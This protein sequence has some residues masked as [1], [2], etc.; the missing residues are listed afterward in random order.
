MII[1]F[2]KSNVEINVW[3]NLINLYFLLLGKVRVFIR[4]PL[5][6][7]I[8]KIDSLK[9]ETINFYYIW[10]LFLRGLLSYLNLDFLRI[11]TISLGYALWWKGGTCLCS[12]LIWVPPAESIFYSFGG[13]IVQRLSAT[14]KPETDK[15]NTF[16]HDFQPVF[17][18]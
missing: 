6:I 11:K 1:L 15:T 7:L 8:W 13:E 14:S 12:S 2:W 16:L 4:N 5:M 9:D 3:W 17:F 10:F 18:S